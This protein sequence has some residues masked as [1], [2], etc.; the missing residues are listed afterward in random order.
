M[1]LQFQTD[2]LRDE[3]DKVKLLPLYFIIASV[4]ILSEVFNKQPF[5]MFSRPLIALWCFF[6]GTRLE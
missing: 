3:N 4:V 6:I 5:F 1:K 2:I